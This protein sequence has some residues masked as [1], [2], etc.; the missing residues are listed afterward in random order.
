MTGVCL[1][2]WELSWWL[3]MQRPPYISVVVRTAVGP[4]NSS[5]L[6]GHCHTKL[7]LPRIGYCCERAALQHSFNRHISRSYY[8]PSKLNSIL[9]LSF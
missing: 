9:L 8:T 5:S 7:G 6:V 4:I 1:L 2:F 3:C